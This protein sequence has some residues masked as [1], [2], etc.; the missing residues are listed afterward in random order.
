MYIPKLFFC[1]SPLP[2]ILYGIGDGG[3][4]GHRLLACLWLKFL[5]DAPF[6]RYSNKTSVHSHLTKPLAYCDFSM[7]NIIQ[8]KLNV[9]KMKSIS[10][11]TK[12]MMHDVDDATEILAI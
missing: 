11:V 8:G 4:P 9:Q 2:I 10:C 5:E 3:S 6:G 7:L 1:H 12:M